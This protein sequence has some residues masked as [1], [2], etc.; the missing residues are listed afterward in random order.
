MF[1]FAPV[2]GVC[3]VVGVLFVMFIGWRLIPADRCGPFRPSPS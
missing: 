2:G 1:D 3:A